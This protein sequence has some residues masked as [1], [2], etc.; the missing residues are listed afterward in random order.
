MRLSMTPIHNRWND[1]EGFVVIG[2]PG[3]SLEEERKNYGLSDREWEVSLLL[4]RG[5]SNNAIADRLCI[6]PGTVKNHVYNIYA[7]TGAGN[8]VELS[9]IFS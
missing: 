9:R 3:R 5:L 6:A 7:K 8:R 4:M 1:C 2:Q